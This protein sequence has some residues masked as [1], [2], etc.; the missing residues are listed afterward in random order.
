MKR[1]VLLTRSAEIDLD[2]ILSWLG[3]RSARGAKNWL[4]ALENALDW[5]AANASSCS[6]AP[7]SDA[8]EEEI[9]ERLFKTKH[10][11]YYR[12]LFVISGRQV[13]VLH[14]R[15]PGQDFVRPT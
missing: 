2:A 8:F 11:R 1:E 4:Q 3:D 5:L 10:G 6:L 15:A 13:R 14:I 9:R 12:L 7:E